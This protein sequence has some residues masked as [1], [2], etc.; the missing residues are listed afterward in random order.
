MAAAPASTMLSTISLG[1]AAAPATNTPASSVR[2]GASLG[3]TVLMKLSVPVARAQ[4]PSGSHPGSRPRDSTTR[5]CSA[6][7]TPPSASWDS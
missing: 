3:F 1:P 4:R 7:C 5:S 2:V 6:T